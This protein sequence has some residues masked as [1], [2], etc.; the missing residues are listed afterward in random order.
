[1]L[2]SDGT[3]VRHILDTDSNLRADR[4]GHT[5]R[6]TSWL[7]SARKVFSDQNLEQVASTT[8][9]E[10]LMTREASGLVA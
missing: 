8:W 2:I 4:I 3:P 9:R 1:L 7:R 5:L 6:H 10:A